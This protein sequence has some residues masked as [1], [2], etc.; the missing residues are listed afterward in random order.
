MVFM[1]PGSSSP[2]DFPEIELKQVLVPFQAEAVSIPVDPAATHVH[3]DFSLAV[4][5][6]TLVQPL[7]QILS[8][9]LLTYILLA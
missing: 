9:G 4:E 1:D 2:L 3:A 6:D 7:F 8:Y 5:T